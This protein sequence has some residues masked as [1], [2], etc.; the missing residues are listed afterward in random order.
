MASSSEEGKG[1]EKAAD[2]NVQTWWRAASEKPGEWLQIDLGKN[3]DVRAV[4]INFADDKI[5]IP[6]PGEIK[7]TQTQPRYIEEQDHVTRWIL[8]GS[9]DGEHYEVLEDKSQAETDL[10]HDLVVM[11]EGKQIRYVKLT[12]FEIP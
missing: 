10:P 9:V 2:E 11:E 6:V 1:P 4:Q 5:D 3:Y 8:E 12:I 7:G